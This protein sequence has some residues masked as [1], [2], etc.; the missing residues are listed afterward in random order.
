VAISL[1]SFRAKLRGDGQT[2]KKLK[3]NIG[4][5]TADGISGAFQF[6]DLGATNYSKRFYRFLLP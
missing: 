5:T 4:V 1:K 6:I 3:L 2:R